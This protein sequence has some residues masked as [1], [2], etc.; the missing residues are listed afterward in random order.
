MILD[1]PVLVTSQDFT[2]LVKYWTSPSKDEVRLIR[3]YAGLTQ[4]DSAVLVGLSHASRWSE[5]ESG[6]RIMDQARWEL[7][8][9]KVG[10]HPKFI[11][12]ITEDVGDKSA[13]GSVANP[14]N[15]HFANS[16]A[17]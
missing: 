17:A 9:I 3:A 10:L 8:L 4:R 5:F 16:I 11:Y 12:R 15:E 7:Y 2:E 1:A 14:S 6:S 13:G